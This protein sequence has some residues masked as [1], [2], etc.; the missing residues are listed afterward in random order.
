MLL[1]SASAQVDVAALMILQRSRRAM[2]RIRSVHPRCI[3]IAYIP[4][5]YVDIQS[6]DGHFTIHINHKA[7]NRNSLHFHIFI[8]L[9]IVHECK[10]IYAFRMALAVV[11]Y[12]CFSDG[13]KTLFFAAIKAAEEP[14]K[15]ARENFIL[16]QVLC[17]LDYMFLRTHKEIINIQSHVGCAH[18]LLCITR[19][20]FFIA[21]PLFNML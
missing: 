6:I 8:K 19:H 9:V 10:L 5:N 15:L 17:I 16:G 11:I 21:R 4:H 7:N 12:Y 18:Y 14:Q 1:L 20:F 13:E 3:N 2:P